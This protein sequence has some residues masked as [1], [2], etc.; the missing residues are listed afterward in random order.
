MD[1][2]IHLT[3]EKGIKSLTDFLKQFKTIGDSALLHLSWNGTPG[4][5]TVIYTPDR[6]IVRYGEKTL[7]D[8]GFTDEITLT[9]V[10]TNKKMSFSDLDH[11]E[12]EIGTE[13]LLD[14]LIKITTRFNNDPCRVTITCGEEQI[15]GRGENTEVVIVAKNINIRSGKM[16]LNFRCSK[17][18]GFDRV[19]NVD[20][21]RSAVFT[22]GEGVGN[23]SVTVDGP[24]IKD[25]TTSIS[26]YATGNNKTDVMTFFVSDL[27]P[28]DDPGTKDPD[29]P[30]PNKKLSVQS[31]DDFTLL[32]STFY[33]RVDNVSY[34]FRF[35]K[36]D[37]VTKSINKT[38]NVTFVFCADQSAPQSNKM[39]IKGDNSN[40]VTAIGALV[41]GEEEA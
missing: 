11:T 35:D 38:D 25:L 14:K 24:S 22:F 32:M 8:L 10:K 13:Q 12:V 18:D 15:V 31:K 9:D 29:A 33:G 37:L 17:V 40:I 16:S 34:K 4:I 7:T 20:V 27:E 26:T 39:F 41:E 2:N 1:F 21:V 28:G 6:S 5:R 19:N 3:A 30:T 36:Y 23:I